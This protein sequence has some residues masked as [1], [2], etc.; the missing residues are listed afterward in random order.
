MTMTSTRSVTENNQ[1]TGR[2]IRRPVPWL[3]G[4]SS[5][6]ST[7]DTTTVS[8]TSNLFPKFPPTSAGG[9]S[10]CPAGKATWETSN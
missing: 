1:G 4:T 6:S 8:H 9:G 3:F 5:V 2:P 7:E 10:R